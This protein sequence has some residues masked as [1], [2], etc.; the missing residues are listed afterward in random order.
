MPFT[1]I[2]QT[3]EE[4]RGSI[5][6]QYGGVEFHTATSG[7]SS[8]TFIDSELEATDDYINGREW[9]GTSG[10]ND[11]AK[12]I[13]SNYVGSTV[14]GTLRGDVLAAVVA[15]GDTYEL[16]DSDV[17]VGS[18][19]DA[20]NRA[21]RS[22]PRK[23]SPSLRDV[24]LHTSSAINNF[25]IPTAV[26][27]ISQVQMR[28]NHT[29]KVIENCDGAWSES[30]GTGVTV[31]A[32][33][34]DRRE[35]AA[36]NKFVITAAASAGDIT[37]SQVVSL[38]LSK[39]THVEFWFKSTVTLT[40][41]QAK[42]VLSSTANAATETE[43]LSVPAITANTWTW[44]SVALANPLSDTAI[45]STG[46]EYDAD[47]GAVTYQIDG[48]RATVLNSEDWLTIHRNFVHWDQ[49]NRSFSIDVGNAPSGIS[50]ALLKLLGVKKPT[51]L[52][53]DA[54]SCDVE[55]EY[56]INQS[57]ANL[58]R[59]RGDR[60]GG[61]RDAA[62]IEADRYEALAQLALAGSQTPSGVLWISN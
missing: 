49:D 45:I 3:R 52:N 6:R 9:L 57:V 46:V 31:T 14:T 50:Y 38:D 12:R 4:L 21:I 60:R 8:S 10:T 5:G 35:G 44:C 34:E 32:E 15:D 36:S 54:T 7:G 20:I 51:E 1:G 13:V 33:T 25:V 24:S 17:K 19:H 47:I 29:E 39:Y 16:W 28:V 2:P 48:I 22:M 53:A 30:S 18:V 62:M 58:L 41:G 26:Q 23:G 42:L 56:I 61:N 37:A 27:G 59:A 11:E 43:L 40:S 55:P